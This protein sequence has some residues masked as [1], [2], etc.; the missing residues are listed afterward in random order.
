[1]LVPGL[2]APTVSF[3]LY[4]L[5]GVNVSFTL[6]TSS[7]FFS[8]SVICASFAP[9]VFSVLCDLSTIYVLSAPSTSSVLYCPSTICALS[10]LS[11]Y[12]MTCSICIFYNFS[13]IFWYYISSIRAFTSSKK[14]INQYYIYLSY[15]TLCISHYIIQVNIE[16]NCG[17]GC[18][19]GALRSGTGDL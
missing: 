17:L 18:L 14:L 8:S 7:V 10:T 3:V 11:M 2:S 9:F 16:V 4:N 13:Y 5:L 1:M 19:Y 15:I 6:S 12:S